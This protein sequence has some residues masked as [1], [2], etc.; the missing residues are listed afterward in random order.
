MPFTP[1]DQNKLYRQNT[2][3]DLVAGEIIEQIPTTA[4][5]VQDPMRP[6][7][8]IG[9]TNIGTNQGPIT[10]QWPIEAKTLS[11]A[12]TNWVTGLEAV[13]NKMNSDAI[14]NKILSGVG[15]KPV[16]PNGKG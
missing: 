8:F 5:G 2:Y 16:R 9:K 6:V 7:N 3:T 10:V 4:D 11:E 14:Q 13:V 12:I 15:Q 1:I